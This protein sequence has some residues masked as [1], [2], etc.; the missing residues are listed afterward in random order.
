[1]F[2]QSPGRLLESETPAE[3]RNPFPATG[4]VGQ[5]FDWPG[6]SPSTNLGS[7]RAG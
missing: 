1:V 2:G 6:G 7:I 3:P 5:G 4:E